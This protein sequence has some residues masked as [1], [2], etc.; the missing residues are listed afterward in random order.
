MTITLGSLAFD[1]RTAVREKYEEIGGRDARVV[2]LSGLI[3]GEATVEAVEVRL[4][5]ILAAA[6][7]EDYTALS[8]RP[9]RRL[10]VRRAQFSR[11]IS[12]EKRVGSFELK[13]ES[14][15]P[16]EESIAA[17]SESWAVV[18]SGDT[19]LFT[20]AGN[21]PSLPV[22]T[23]VASGSLVNP[24]IGDGARGIVYNGLVSD[25]QTLVFDSAQ[26]KAA[27]DGLDVT[28]YCSGSFPRLYPGG[29]TLA[30]TDDPGSSHTAAATVVFR[31]R[32]W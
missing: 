15:D 22:V 8:V 2:V 1:S 26:E 16:F 6:S 14:R 9:G 29:T 21:A 12:R 10:W 18:A 24:G 7:E 4:D 32:W 30:Y 31:D 23:L 19:R 28:P 11:G 27:L 13:L 20:P 3:V 17:A 25:G 5:A